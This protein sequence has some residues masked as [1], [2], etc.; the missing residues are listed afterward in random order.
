MVSQLITNESKVSSVRR[1]GPKKDQRPPVTHCQAGPDPSGPQRDATDTPSRTGHT[2][3]RAR[4]PTKFK[5]DCPS[6]GMSTAAWKGAV[7]TLHT[8]SRGAKRNK[9][10]PWRLKKVIPLTESRFIQQFHAS[11][12]FSMRLVQ[13]PNCNV[14][15]TDFEFS[16]E[17]HTYNYGLKR[18]FKNRLFEVA[19]TSKEYTRNFKFPI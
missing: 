9:V 10:K 6:V 15:V 16:C 2:L 19:E 5:G 13:S 7:P 3:K 4:V 18:L 1:T 8:A 17:L 12:K 11:L 14:G